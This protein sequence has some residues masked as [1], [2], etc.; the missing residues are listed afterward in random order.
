MTYRARMQ[1]A[2]F[3]VY[4]HAGRRRRCGRTPATAVPSDDLGAGGGR[5]LDEGGVQVA[6]F[7]RRRVLGAGISRQRQGQLAPLGIDHDRLVDLLPRRDRGRVE[8][9]VLEPA[10]G[11]GRQSVAAALVAGEGGLVDEHHP[12]AEAGQ[13]DGGRATRRAGADDRHVGVGRDRRAGRSWRPWSH[14]RSAAG[15]ADQCRV[16]G[17]L[18]GRRRRS[19]PSGERRTAGAGAG[20]P[21]AATAYTIVTVVWGQTV[22]CDGD[23]R[24]WPDGN[25]RRSSSKVIV[26]N[27]YAPGQQPQRVTHFAR[28]ECVSRWQP[29]K[30]HQRATHSLRPGVGVPLW[31][32]DRRPAPPP[33]RPA[34]AGRRLGPRRPGRRRRP[35]GPAVPCPPA[36]VPVTPARLAARSNSAATSAG[37]LRWAPWP[38]SLISAISPAGRAAASCRTDRRWWAR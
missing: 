5:H 20:R 7:G 17:G 28:G 27:L 36:Q 31:L 13:G 14:R 33:A 22:D 11:R 21:P 15:Q 2:V 29:W 38:A 3:G 23:V 26:T 30:R 37:W 32:R 25:N 1:L 4:R 9:Q 8:A 16:D 10:E 18:V 24:I 34:P 12:A 35:A 19:A 6:P